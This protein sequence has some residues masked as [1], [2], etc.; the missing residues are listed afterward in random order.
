[1]TIW[2]VIYH[3]VLETVEKP[4]V[5][6]RGSGGAYKAARNYGKN[7][8]MVVVYR[9]ISKSDGFCHNGILIVHETQGRNHMATTLTRARTH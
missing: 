3:E 9:E 8:W 7:K 2:P 6:V 4:D 5:I 1:M